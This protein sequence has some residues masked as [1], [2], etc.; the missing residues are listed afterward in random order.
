MEGI[1][2]SKENVIPICCEN[3][4]YKDIKEGNI[5]GYIISSIIYLENKKKGTYRD[6]VFKYISDTHFVNICKKWY[7]TVIDKLLWEELMCKHTCAKKETLNIVN[8]M[9]QL[10]KLEAGLESRSEN[11]K[12]HSVILNLSLWS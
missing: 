1:I 12:E 11:L 4:C 5:N 3:H 7:D 8:S 10:P 9:Q 6:N 2:S